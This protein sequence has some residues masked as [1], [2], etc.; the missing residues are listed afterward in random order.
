MATFNTICVIGLGYIGLPTAVA[1]AREGRIVIGVDID[2]K[3]VNKINR[4]ET[5]FN[6]PELTAALKSAVENNR[7]FA[8]TQVDSADVFLIAVPTP[9]DKNLK[10][11]LSYIE[12]VAEA[13]APVLNKGNLVVL[14]STSPV[15][16]TQ[17]L[18][19]QLKALR[20]DLTFPIEIGENADINIAYCPERVL[21]TRIMA[22]LIENDRI[23]GGLTPQ[24]T[25]SAVDLYRIFVKG[26]L[27]PTDAR[28]AEMCKLTEN[29][30][31]DVNI[32]CAN[33]LSMLCDRFNINV[34]EL[35][36]LANRHPRVNILEAGPGV[37]GH[38]IAVD[39]WFIVSQAPEL[40]RLIQTAREVNDSKP[41]WVI[42]KVK[43]TLA[44]C[45]TEK[46]ITP[47]QVSIA[48][49]GLTFKANAD[50]LRESPALEIV[51]NLASWHTGE[52]LAVE[53]HIAERPLQLALNVKMCD[54]STALQNAD[55]LVLLVD[56]KEFRSYP[57]E[58]IRQ[59]FIVDT[60]GV[61]RQ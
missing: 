5:H 7:L 26:E 49:L 33:E 61:W 44:D 37:G 46:N 17:K 8:T 23:I 12:A 10:P 11:D 43:A 24:C 2:E 30:F 45:V 4:G 52:L 18:A 58:K 21:P 27:L 36:A 32:A 28:T 14:E 59:K 29:S 40:S 25:Q 39:P 15:G 31:R 38:C 41:R 55:I 6:E 54:F 13:I 48:C 60:R 3:V 51:Q 22:E 57:S 47:E 20:S 56:H 34:W 50:D 35:V 16:T 19:H 1:L 53:P 42:E 9:L